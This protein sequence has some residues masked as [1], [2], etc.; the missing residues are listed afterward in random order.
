[1]KLAPT[2][3]AFRGRI[4]ILSLVI[5]VGFL[6]TL[7]GYFRVQVLNQERYE[8][9]GQKYRIKTMPIKATRGYIYDRN[10]QLLA[11]NMPTYNLVLL[12]D[13][14]E[15]RWSI[16]RPNLS[17]FLGIP[18]DELHERFRGGSVLFSKPVLLKENV[19]YEETLRI[20]RQSRRY[21][22]LGIDTTKRRTY[23]YPGMFS[24]V[25]GYV[26]EASSSEMKRNPDL[27]LG[28]VIGKSGM[29]LAY[30]DLLTGQDGERTI[31]ID[32]RGVYRSQEVTTTPVPG[33]DLYLSLD[34][35]LQALAM[36]SMEG[37]GGSVLMMDVETGEL[38]VYLSS[39]SFDLNLFT[40]GFSRKK[41]QELNNAVS[42]PFLNRPVK[43]AYAP[44]SVF[45]LVT[46]M[47]GLKLG[48]I[49][50]A[51]EVMCTGSYTLNNHTSRCHKE[52]GHG[53]V[54]LQEAIQFSC[55]VYFYDMANNLNI[56]D[57]AEI[58]GDFGFGSA[59][60]IDLIGENPGLMPNRAWKRKRYKEIWYPGETLS[61]SIGQGALLST[62]I[63]LAVLMATI[64]A[65]GRVPQPHLLLKSGKGDT[66]DV[67]NYEARQI[68]GIDRDHY[69][70]MKEAMWR[71]VNQD[72]GTGANARVPG[73]DVCGKTGTAQLI[74]FRKEEEDDEK[75]L[76]AW[77]A[78]FAPRNNAKIAV[79]VLVEQAGHG[80]H[81]A[82]PIAKTLIEAWQ[83]RHQ[84]E[85]DPS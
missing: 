16:L 65:E 39:P 29:E 59:T 20:K 56:D 49:T 11:Q 37:R 50:P 83:E 3:L 34:Y 53:W 73:M 18:E 48:K 77:F 36:K 63:Q 82:A 13:E 44:G 74:T 69:R 30:N 22:G 76:N 5:M 38:L 57:L 2:P 19:N 28:Q 26:G 4:I 32:N 41:W 47:A 9:L 81:R 51:T 15:T 25:L 72:R 68:E 55:N 64:A 79:I 52:D 23:N 71:V 66:F 42:S 75:L 60:G 24:H 43:G 54:N 8:Q 67:I 33:D 80:G 58:A 45:K 14:M 78:G 40:T 17:G 31:H 61:V 84:L 7:I 70:V 62:P 1:M 10:G 85:V 21:P 46:A 27:K 35:D 12:R 6:I